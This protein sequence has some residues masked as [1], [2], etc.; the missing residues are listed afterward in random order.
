MLAVGCWMVCK[1]AG[2]LTCV[3]SYIKQFL[4]IQY[5]KHLVSQSV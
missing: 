2:L 1:F 3:Y 4:L 5:I